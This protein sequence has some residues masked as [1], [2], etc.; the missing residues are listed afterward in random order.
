M[1]EL[2]YY[3]VI[4]TSSDQNIS[5]AQLLTKPATLT[6]GTGPLMGLTG[7]KVVHGVVTHFKRISGSRDQA[8]YQIIIEP[9]LSLL[10]KQFRTHRFFVNKSVPEVVTEVL[11]EHGLKGWEYEF[12][13]KA[14]YPKRE[15]INQY[16]ES[17]LAFIQRLLAE[18]GIFYWFNRLREDRWYAAVAFSGAAAGDDAAGTDGGGNGGAGADAGAGYPRNGVSPRPLPY[19]AEAAGCDEYMPAGQPEAP[20]GDGHACHGCER[21][22]AVAPEH[23][24]PGRGPGLAAGRRPARRHDGAAARVAGRAPGCTYAVM[25]CPAFTAGCVAVLQCGTD[26][27]GRAHGGAASPK[28]ATEQKRHYHHSPWTLSERPGK[29]SAKEER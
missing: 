12:T 17:D 24:Q 23:G 9:F 27:A 14:D 16:Q 3:Q 19:P 29:H 18:V 2:Y 25:R 20:S 1:S 26:R 5:S 8:T 4:F 7:Q 11:Q 21:P 22:G 13:L 15:Q 28:C 10:R 6:M